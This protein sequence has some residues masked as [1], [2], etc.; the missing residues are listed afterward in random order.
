M[1]YFFQSC[2]CFSISGGGY[3]APECSQD[4]GVISGG[5][6]LVVQ[7]IAGRNLIAS[8]G[9]AQRDHRDAGKAQRIYVSLNGSPGD[10]KMVRQF[11]GRGSAVVEQV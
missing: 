2:L 9:S 3:Q 11:T 6:K 1:G 7:L 10:L 4:T 5:G 8:R